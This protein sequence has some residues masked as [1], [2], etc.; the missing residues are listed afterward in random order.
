[1]RLIKVEREE[2]GREG[3]GECDGAAVHASAAFVLL[4]GIGRLPFRGERG[5]AFLF[6]L[7]L[8]IA[9]TKSPTKSELSANLEEKKKLKLVRGHLVR[10]LEFYEQICKDA[11]VQNFQNFF[12]WLLTFGIS[13]QFVVWHYYAE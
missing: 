13:I 1:M 12:L 10:S 2:E 6:P 3:A 8:L 11:E 5:I 9:K 4:N 7:L